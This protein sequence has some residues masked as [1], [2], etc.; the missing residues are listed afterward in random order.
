MG[1][2][3]P[4]CR[5]K[6]RPLLLLIANSPVEPRFVQLDH[7]CGWCIANVLLIVRRA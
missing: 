7:S 5:S 4:I 3:V 2:S 1:Q 6:T